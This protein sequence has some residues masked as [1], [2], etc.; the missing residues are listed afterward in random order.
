MKRKPCCNKRTLLI[1]TPYASEE[2]PDRIAWLK[3]GVWERLGIRLAEI[4]QDGKPLTVQFKS[5]D[6]PIVALGQIEY[7]AEIIIT[8]P[9]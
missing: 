5:S 8:D 3:R 9:L 4:M 6:K 7:K 2:L 1:R